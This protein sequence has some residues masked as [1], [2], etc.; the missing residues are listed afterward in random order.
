MTLLL[1]ELFDPFVFSVIF[2]VAGHPFVVV[3][4]KADLEGHQETRKL[5]E[6]PG[7]N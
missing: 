1:L 6:K 5:V 4:Y 2:R 7:D 3:V